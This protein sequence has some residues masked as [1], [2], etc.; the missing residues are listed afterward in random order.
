MRPPGRRDR[1]YSDLQWSASWCVILSAGG[2]GSW[3]AGHP[4]KG[5]DE[6][7]VRVHSRVG[8]DGLPARGTLE[9]ALGA[10]AAHARL[11][12]LVLP[13][14]REYSGLALGEVILLE[15]DRA[16][17]APHLFM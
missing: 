17:E 9:G 1:L 16:L 8:L 14:A 5:S 7:T 12:K 6:S 2:R 4:L 3:A 11:A 13:A 15:A 10:Q